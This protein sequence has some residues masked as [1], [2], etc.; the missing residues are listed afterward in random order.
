MNR[1]QILRVFNESLTAE[2]QAWVDSHE[3]LVRQLYAKNA[4]NSEVYTTIQQVATD[5]TNNLFAKVPSNVAESRMTKKASR[6]SFKKF[7]NEDE[8]RIFSKVKEAIIDAFIETTVSTSTVQAIATELKRKKLKIGDVVDNTKNYHVSTNAI[9]ACSYS[10]DTEAFLLNLYSKDLHFGANAIGAGEIVFALILKNARLLDHTSRNNKADILLETSEGQATVEV[11]ANGGM[12]AGSGIH[13]KPLGADKLRIAIGE[14]IAASF[15]QALTRDTN[16]QFRDIFN[17]LSNHSAF[18]RKSYKSFW[19]ELINWLQVNLANATVEDLQNIL[20]VSLIE[21]Y[22]I[23]FNREVEDTFYK[24][25]AQFEVDCQ[26]FA[27]HLVSFAT[28]ENSPITVEKLLADDTSIRSMIYLGMSIMGEKDNQ[29]K[30]TD[31]VI[32]CNKKAAEKGSKLSKIFAYAI[33]YAH[34]SY[35]DIYNIWDTLITQKKFSPQARDNGVRGAITSVS[36]KE[37][38]QEKYARQNATSS[39]ASVR[40]AVQ[41]VDELEKRVQEYLDLYP[42]KKTYRIGTFYRYFD[43]DASEKIKY[44]AN[45]ILIDWYRAEF[46]DFRTGRV[47]PID[48]IHDILYAADIPEEIYIVCEALG[49][50][51]TD[52]IR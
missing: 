7:F 11:K 50:N 52:Y 15:P 1:C 39:R 8:S 21:V 3:D 35:R 28:V 44:V 48:D 20:T 33:D 13:V 49:E 45:D 17:Q 22:K 34:D 27:E 2:E 36:I 18:S 40:V 46:W 41:D 47:P 19:V 43:E 9:T 42:S 37:A 31:Y 14:A 23:I 29:A 12:L 4:D 24:Y 32:F 16:K 51:P 25:D 5:L 6:G 10:P 26:A 30:T 38:D